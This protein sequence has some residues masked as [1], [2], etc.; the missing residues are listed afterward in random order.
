[1]ADGKPGTIDAASQV[2]VLAF[3]LVD[4]TL[5]DTPTIL[6]NALQSALVQN[7]I[8]KTLFD[9][10]AKAK[11]GIISID[12]PEEGRKLLEAMG[13]GVVDAATED[14]LRQIKKTQQYKA[15]RLEARLLRCDRQRHVQH[16]HRRDVP[17]QSRERDIR[18]VVQNGCCEIRT[19]RKHRAEG[20]RGVQ[21]GGLLTLSVDL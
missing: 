13:E 5:P 18:C 19:G 6:A 20:R 3:D 1:M 2:I 9:Y 7:A 4:K 12:S 21:Y 10:A 17:G 15:R 11:K 14:A 8:K 16:R